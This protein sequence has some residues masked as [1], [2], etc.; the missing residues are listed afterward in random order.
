MESD[1]EN[2]ESQEMDMAQLLAEHDASTAAKQAE[3]GSI[4]MAKV[5]SVSAEGVLVDIG[6]KKEALI[7]R[8]E[9]KEEPVF[10]PGESIPVL[11]S[12]GGRKGGQVSWRKAVEQLAWE[13]IEQSK[14]RRLPVTAT[15]LGDIKGGLQLECEGAL[16]AFMPASHVDIRPTADLK[17]FK[18]ETFQTY[19]VETD[20]P[21]G[22]LVLSRKLWLSQENQKKKLDTLAEL[23]EG[24]TRQ[25]VVTGITTFGAFVDLGGIEG[26]LHIGELEWAR[27][28]KVSDVL[29][30]GQEISVKI[31]KY[32]PQTEKISLSRRELLPHPWDDVEA[33]FPQGTVLEGRITNVADFGCFVEVAPQVEGLLHVSEVSWSDANPKLKSLYKAG[34]K[35]QVKVIGVSREKEKISLSRKR[36]L[37]SPWQTLKG[38]YP[39]GSLVKVVITH[40]VPFGAFARLPDGIEGLIHI[41]DF[42]WVK[43]IVHPQDVVKPGQELDVKVLEISPEKEKISFGLK[44]VKPNPFETYRKG[45][46]VSGTITQVT[47]LGALLEIEPGLEGYI[48][49]SEASMERVDS[50][51]N[52]FKTGDSVEAK[53]MNIEPKERKIQLSVRRL[54][55]ELQRQ[56]VKKYSAHSPRPNLGD[57]LDS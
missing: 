56:A 48:P 5:V 19:I 37:E 2:P 9:F 26:L 47:D 52:V 25:G 55:Q 15:V 21:K 53:V 22:K 40:L 8:D 43:R 1:L 27:T 7:P 45:A 12:R 10:K 14:A 49:V 29:K 3:S 41:S 38:K 51:K 13:H 24:D 57:L 23:K 16:N 17:R 35:I 44:Q 18:G 28:R 50:A 42:S 39:A 31:L 20:R 33:R 54:D 34:Q 32:D 6:E 4:L 46:V 36:T 11:Q 30:T